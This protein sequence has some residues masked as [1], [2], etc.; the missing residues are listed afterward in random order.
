MLLPHSLQPVMETA[1]LVIEVV[2]LAGFFNSCLE[3]LYW[4]FEYD[5]RVLDARFNATKARFERWG[6]GVGIER[7]QLRHT[8]HPAL[9]H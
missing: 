6:L 8:H 1:G 4:T 3:A 5:S 2:E 7:G 9:D